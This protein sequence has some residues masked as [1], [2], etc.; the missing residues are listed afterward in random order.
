MN[1]QMK[2]GLPA[3]VIRIYH[4]AVPFFG[5]TLPARDL[6]GRQEKMAER[7]AVCFAGLIE[8]GEMLA[9]DDQNMRR[10][11]RTDVVKGHA[12]LIFIDEFGRNFAPADLAEN[13]I[14]THIEC[15]I[16]A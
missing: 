12:G 10:R 2:N 5:K 4:R 9:R 8:R 14:L 6:A 7:F 3:G 13:T 15:I 11:L 16:K 1:M